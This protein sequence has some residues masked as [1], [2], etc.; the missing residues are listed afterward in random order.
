MALHELLNGSY[1]YEYAELMGYTT[2]LSSMIDAQIS[3]KRRGQ[4]G[5]KL[6]AED[7]K[8]LVAAI[9]AWLEEMKITTVRFPLP[10]NSTR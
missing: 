10:S 8:D 4:R 3:M 9:V 5:K 7:Y 6:G 1:S 2:I